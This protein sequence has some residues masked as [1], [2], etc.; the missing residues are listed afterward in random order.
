MRWTY[1][2]GVS[3]RASF[4]LHSLTIIEGVAD[5]L[6]E[7]AILLPPFNRVRDEYRGCPKE[8]P[9]VVCSSEGRGF[10]VHDHVLS[11]GPF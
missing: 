2:K 10:T 7:L 9:R 5:R 6:Q 8:V 4:L 3:N 1:R 11:T